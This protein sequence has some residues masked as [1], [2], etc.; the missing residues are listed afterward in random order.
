MSDCLK[1]LAA[2]LV[3]SL[4]VSAPSSADENWPQFRGAQSLGIASG[5]NLPDKW[6]DTENVAWKTDVAGRGWS[7]PVVWDGKIFLST[8]VNLGEAEEPKKG[9]YFGG[10]R[11]EPPKSEHEW[12]V[13]CLDLNDGHKLWEQT[14]HKG[15]PATPIHLKNSY[16][17]ETPVTD[18]ERLYVYFGNVG[19][20]CYDFDGKQLWKHDI[21]PHAVRFGWGTAASPVVYDGKLFLVNDNDDESYLLA[22]NSKTGEQIFRVER[23]EKS[24]WATPYVW[25]N[26]Q[27]TEL[28]VPGTGKIRS[29]DLEGRLLW[30]LAGMSSITIAMPYADGDTL[31]VSSGY[32]LD[33]LKPIYA[34]RPGAS[35]DISLT[36]G[37]TSNDYILWSVSDGG[38]YN[39][40]TL[41]YQDVVYVLYDQGFFAAF[42]AKTGG[43]VYTKKRI[44]EGKAF[45]ASPW[46]YNDKIF[47]L[48]EDGVTFVIAAGKDFEIL[49]TNTLAADD[50]CMAT[51]AIVG[52][53]LLIRTSA[54]VYC[55]E[56][57]K[58]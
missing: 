2:V 5:E 1:C 49:H 12:R 44:P 19:V 21:E 55:I 43:P 11:P 27:R 53:K 50:M 45:T 29:Y 4:V 23:D 54:R 25:K 15:V 48:N 33:K 6:S 30:E 57:S 51:P 47:C 41:L 7:S 26:S 37:A 32:V 31:Y 3:L 42:D 38:P 8:V 13:V 24:N 18:G 10:N 39:P 16:A 52:N 34:I 20:F 14:C 56:K 46:A 9:L 36:E 28:V 35:G 58:H 22:L 40:S 17:S